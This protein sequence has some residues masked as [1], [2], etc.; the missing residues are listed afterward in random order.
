MLGP[1]RDANSGLFEQR[2]RDYVHDAA[3]A[4]PP[5]PPGFHVRADDAWKT[6]MHH[7]LSASQHSTQP[8]PRSRSTAPRRPA[9]PR[10]ERRLHRDR[11]T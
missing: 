2:A 5:G 9:S 6:V 3:E 10:F 7:Q 4:R 8:C 1:D 11:I